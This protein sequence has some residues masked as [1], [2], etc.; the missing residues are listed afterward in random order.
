MSC[1][2]SIQR[3]PIGKA[4]HHSDRP[5]SFE[6][7]GEIQAK[8]QP[9]CSLESGAAAVQ[10]LQFVTGLEQSTRMQ[11]AFRAPLHSMC[12]AGQGEGSVRNGGLGRIVFAYFNRG[13]QY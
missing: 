6:M 8:Q 1:G 5:S 3:L 10:T 4:L 13:V 12:R 7:D 2:P 11:M 9:P